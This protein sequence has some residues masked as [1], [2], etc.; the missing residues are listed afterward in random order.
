VGIA[1]GSASGKT[2][3]LKALT[4]KFEPGEVAVITQDNYY[5]EKHQQMRDA[6]GTIN[7]DLPD[8]ID[9]VALFQDLRHLIAGANVARQEYTFN[10]TR[11]VASQIEV[12]PA[13]IIIVEGLFVFHFT[14]LSQMLDLKVY[15][16]ARD[17][18][19]LQRRLKRDAIERGY[20]ESDVRY[21]WEHHVMPC[22]HSYLKPYR[23]SCDLIVT[24]DQS[25]D[26]GLDV[27]VDH[28]KTKVQETVC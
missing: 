26:S 2:S 3:F 18:I 23:D 15:I 11:A 24:N 9:R 27:L 14:E 16:D 8:A 5:L 20:P 28:L 25:F 10:N 21:R 6:Q 4:A 7:F 13:P 1:G 12:A 17:E 22:Y 19:K